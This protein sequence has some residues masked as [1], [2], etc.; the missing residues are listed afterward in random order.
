MYAQFKESIFEYIF[1]MYWIYKIGENFFFK[2]RSIYVIHVKYFLIF[3]YLGLYILK[4]YNKKKQFLN[5]MN[6]FL[7]IQIKQ[8]QC[9]PYIH[10]NASIHVNSTQWLSP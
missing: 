3:L 8:R 9:I 6:S 2:I 1:I 4:L 10:V 7:E 5:P